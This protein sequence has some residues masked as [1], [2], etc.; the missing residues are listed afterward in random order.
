MMA[1]LSSYCMPKKQADDNPPEVDIPVE[2]GRR[3]SRH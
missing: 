2:S 1:A 3:E